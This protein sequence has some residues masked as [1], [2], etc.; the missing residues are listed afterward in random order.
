MP[1]L[2]RRTAFVADAS[3]EPLAIANNRLA[4][5]IVPFERR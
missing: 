1:G 2:R 3:G 4:P 5:Q